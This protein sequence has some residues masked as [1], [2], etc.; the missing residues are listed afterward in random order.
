MYSFSYV[1]V[2]F[3]DSERFIKKPCLIFGVL[4]KNV[5]V[6]LF[7]FWDGGII[8]YSSS[9]RWKNTDTVYCIPVE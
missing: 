2:M 4:L 3:S 5:C 9:N 7:T 1:F 6:K 8:A